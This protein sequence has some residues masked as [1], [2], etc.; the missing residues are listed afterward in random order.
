[1][2]WFQVWEDILVNAWNSKCR[3]MWSSIK[4]LSCEHKAHV[5]QGWG[6]TSNCL[7]TFLEENLP[8]FYSYMMPIINKICICMIYENNTV[9]FPPRSNP[10]NNRLSYLTKIMATC[11]I[12][13]FLKYLKVTDNCKYSQ[14]IFRKKAH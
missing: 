12:V 7:S 3:E 13:V 4:V 9:V 14:H 2:I 11:L 6:V 10:S 8:D 1:M 5:F